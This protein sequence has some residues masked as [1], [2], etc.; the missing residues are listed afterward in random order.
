MIPQ[1]FG[2]LVAGELRPLIG[3]ED[4]WLAEPGKGLAQRR[5]TERRRQR[6]GQP[7]GQLVGS[8]SR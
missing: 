1:H 2:E 4:A 3:I 6:V 7:P 8:P 5:D